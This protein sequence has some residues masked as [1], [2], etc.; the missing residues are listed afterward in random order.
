MTRIVVNYF[1]PR[2]MF[3]TNVA[4]M[5]DSLIVTGKASFYPTH[6]VEFL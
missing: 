6:L 2:P 5:C 1:L 3:K 4:L